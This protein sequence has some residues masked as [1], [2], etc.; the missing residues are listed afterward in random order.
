MTTTT[1]RTCYWFIPFTGMAGIAE[2]RHGGDTVRC[3]SY[4]KPLT[5][6]LRKTFEQY[7]LL[8]DAPTMWDHS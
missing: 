4:D 2:H 8:L 5:D 3:I 7:G 1:T 6:E